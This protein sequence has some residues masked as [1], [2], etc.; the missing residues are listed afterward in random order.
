MKIPVM[1]GVID[2]RI[3]ANYH[4]DPQVLARLLPPPFRPKLVAGKALVGICLI[5][6]KHI[7]PTFLPAWLGLSSENAAHRAAVEWDEDGA[8]RQGVFIRRRDTNSRLNTLL[9]GRIFPGVHHQAT[10]RVEEGADRFAVAVQSDDGETRVSIRGHRAD[11]LPSSSVF[12]SLDEAS[13]FF[14]AGSLGY[15]ST[16][17][18]TRFD[19]LELQCR[20]WSAEPL[21]VEEV[22]SNFFEDR[23]LFPPGSIEFDSALLMQRIDHEWRGRE[24]LCCGS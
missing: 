4:V 18:Q 20:N 5:R 24:D 19:G 1:R 22:H 23:A 6:L 12:R 13:D 8:V 16:A 2:R 7:R 21:A 10:F 11:Q 9:G 3:L 15:S 17:E 14:A